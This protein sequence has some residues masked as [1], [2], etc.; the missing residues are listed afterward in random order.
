[1]KYENSVLVMPLDPPFE[2]EVEFIK[3]TNNEKQLVVCKDD[4]DKIR[5][6]AAG[7]LEG[8]RI[9]LEADDDGVHIRVS[10]SQ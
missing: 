10:I 5:G 1:M 2:G 3:F 8:R 7:D 4:G 6:L 9:V